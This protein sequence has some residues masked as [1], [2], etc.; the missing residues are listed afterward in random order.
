MCPA[1]DVH[2]A[3]STKPERLGGSGVVRGR[4]WLRAAPVVQRTARGCAYGKPLAV[5]LGIQ[6]R[7]GRCRRQAQDR[8]MDRA[9][10]AVFECVRCSRCRTGAVCVALD[11]SGSRGAADLDPGQARVGADRM[12]QRRCDRC[13]QDRQDS[14]PV[15][16]ESTDSNAMHGGNCRDRNFRR[17]TTLLPRA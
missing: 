3:R 15:D 2:P 11:P 7:C 16:H 14:D 1:V 12:R 8:D 10:W 13:Q 9:I 4:A 6:G 5:T 17:L